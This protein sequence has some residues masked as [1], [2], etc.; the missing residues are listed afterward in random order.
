MSFLDIQTHVSPQLLIWL[1]LSCLTEKYSDCG[2]QG[3]QKEDGFFVAI[4]TLMIREIPKLFLNLTNIS[5]FKL[6]FTS[7]S[8]T[9]SIHQIPQQQFHILRGGYKSGNFCQT[10]INIQIVRIVQNLLSLLISFS[11]FENI[12]LRNYWNGCFYQGFMGEVHICKRKLT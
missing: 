9:D 12:F 1:L 5:Y 8:R 11:I 6:K 7:Y 4:W 10:R 3:I 2:K